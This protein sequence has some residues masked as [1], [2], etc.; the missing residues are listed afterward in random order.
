MFQHGMDRQSRPVRDACATVAGSVVLGTLITTFSGGGVTANVV[1]FVVGL[2][3]ATVAAA[4]I[5]RRRPRFSTA[6]D[7]VTLARAVLAGGCATMVVLSLFG[8]LPLRSWPLF[9]V[10][11]PTLLM[12]AVDGWVARR[13]G[14]ASAQGARL[15]METDAAFL[16]VLSVPVAFVVGPW[17]LAIGAMR[18]LFVAASW[19]RPALRAPLAFSN[20][21]RVTAGLQGVALAVALLPITPVA[22][23][24]VV[25]L[26]ALVLLTVSFGKDVAT[27][28]R[29]SLPGIQP[30]RRAE[31]PTP[32]HSGQPCG[33]Q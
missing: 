15:D 11:V 20:F 25:T 33:F 12:D 9:L 23:A 22:L 19:W 7:R 26:L 29:Q 2:G 31:A 10:A 4:S 32:V 27:L 8:V 3:L 28:E 17:V 13:S 18:Y 30:R 1:A 14:T 5:V 21:R 6:A 16:L 24:T